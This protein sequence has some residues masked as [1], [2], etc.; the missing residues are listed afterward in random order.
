VFTLMKVLNCADDNQASKGQTGADW[1]ILRNKKLRDF[2][3]EPAN[4]TCVGVQ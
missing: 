3:C 2:Y 4:M 1:Q